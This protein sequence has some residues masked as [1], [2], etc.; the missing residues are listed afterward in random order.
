MIEYFETIWNGE[1]RNSL[2]II[3]AFIIFSILYT[4]FMFSRNKG[5]V[6]KFLQAHPNAAKAIVKGA[7]QGRFVFE[8]VNGEKPVLGS[9]GIKTA[10]YLIPGENVISFHYTWQRP[11]LTGGT[12]QTTIGPV[13][14][15]VQAEP[16]KSYNISFDKKTETCKFEEC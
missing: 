6:Q 9:E 7:A 12:V 3:G 8:S 13:E 15:S 1:S 16:N 4:I 11:K 14:I 2:F 5:K 10:V